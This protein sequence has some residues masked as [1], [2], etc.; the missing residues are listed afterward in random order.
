MFAGMQ[1]NDLQ[2]TKVLVKKCQDAGIKMLMVGTCQP[3]M[4]LGS[5]GCLVNCSSLAEP[6]PFK[7]CT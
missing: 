1:E 4:R 7:L 2:F 6:C 3:P 5:L